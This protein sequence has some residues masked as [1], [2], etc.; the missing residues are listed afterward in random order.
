MHL[1]I[2]QYSNI[3]L[4]QCIT[5]VFVYMSITQ[6]YRKV[7]LNIDRTLQSDRRYLSEF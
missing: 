6:K 2:Q 3:I 4:L 7:N 1:S 5:A